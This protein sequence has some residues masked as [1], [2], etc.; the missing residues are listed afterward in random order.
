MA[1]A[2]GEELIQAIVAGYE[3]QVR[4][5][6]ALGPPAHYDRGFHPT[7]TCGVFGAAAA[8]GRIFC[9]SP[10]RMASAF[11]IA[12]SQ[13]A[14][15]MQFLA[16]GAWTKRSHVG[17]AAM[18]GLI[19]ATMASEGFRGPMEAFEGRRGFLRAYAPKPEPEKAAADLGQRWE[20]MNIAVKPFPSCRFSHAPMDALIRLRQEHGIEA[21]DVEAVEIGIAETG[22]NVI[23]TPDEAKQNPKN[24][25]DGQFS[26]AFCAA[27]TLRE[28]GLTWDDYPKH[29]ADKKTLDLCRRIRCVPDPKAE[30]EYPRNLSGGARVTTKSGTVEAF[31]KVP[32]GEPSNFLTP[33]EQRAKFAGLV[34]P[35]LPPERVD[36]LAGRLLAIRREDDIGEVLRLSRPAA[37][38]TAVEVRAA[39]E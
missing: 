23:G 25:V 21:A 22:W 10:E 31:V 18:S 15:S 20:T 39:G 4:L 6:L 32:K 13:A 37:A 34:S 11:G 16:D 26:M 2:D 7:A 8:A 29:L 30:A 35:Y 36:E 5:S 38:P 33:E 3:V 27:V 19:A 12:L 28:G 9:L 14:G 1:G 17:H 24:V